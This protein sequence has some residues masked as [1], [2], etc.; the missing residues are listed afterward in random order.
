[1]SWDTAWTL[2]H[3][4]MALGW[5][6]LLILPRRPL[7]LS[8]ILFA[9]VGALCLAYAIMFAGLF[10]GWMDPVRVAGAGP[11]N[12]FDYDIA[13]VRNLFLSDG[14]TLL[15]W[16]HYLAFD[17]FVGLWIARDGDGKGVSRWVQAPILLVTL[18]AGPIGLLLWLAVREGRARRARR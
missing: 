14:G 1:M 11:A 2:V 9:C 4:P 17:L 13:G 3:V 16:T 18:M 6:A 10:G 15:G 8:F 7:T 12:L 5:L